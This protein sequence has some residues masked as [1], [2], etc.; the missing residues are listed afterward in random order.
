MLPPLGRRGHGGAGR[1][2][3]VWTSGDLL[4]EHTHDPEDDMTWHS[5]ITSR[6]KLEA[7]IAEIRQTGGTIASCQRCTAGLLV[8]WFTL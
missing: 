2:L 7:L 5:S 1:T 6:D 4:A 3:G 8:T